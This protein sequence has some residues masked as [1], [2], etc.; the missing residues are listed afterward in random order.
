[1]WGW[2]SVRALLHAEGGERWGEV[3]KGYVRQP[4]RDAGEVSVEGAGKCGGWGE[5][6]E[7]AEGR[8]QHG[9]QGP[10]ELG[11]FRPVCSPEAFGHHCR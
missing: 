1:M 4:P 9:W 2:E 10:A 6:W 3:G 5:R 7:G 11:P 8:W